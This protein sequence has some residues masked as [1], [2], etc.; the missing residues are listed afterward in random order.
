VLSVFPVLPIAMQLRTGVAML[1]F[2]GILADYDAV[3]DIDAL[4]RRIEVAVARLVASSKKRKPERD[5][6]GLSLVASV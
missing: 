5:R 4:A 6:R 1:S 3:A 2:F